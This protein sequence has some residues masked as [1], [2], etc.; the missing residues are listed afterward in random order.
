MIGKYIGLGAL[1]GFVRT[2]CIEPRFIRTEQTPEQNYDPTQQGALYTQ[3]ARW[4]GHY[5][6]YCPTGTAVKTS[7]WGKIKQLYR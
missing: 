5:G 6:Y 4:N 2:V 3:Y 7:T 1:G